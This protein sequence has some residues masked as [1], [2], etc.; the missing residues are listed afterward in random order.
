MNSSAVPSPYFSPQP[1]GLGPEQRAA[2]AR[3]EYVADCAVAFLA[4][5]T[6]PLDRAVFHHLQDYVAGDATLGQAIG[7]IVDHVAR[8]PQ[9]FGGLQVS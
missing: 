8:E 7:R 2:W 5:K 3:R 6:N 4:T 9:A 1:S